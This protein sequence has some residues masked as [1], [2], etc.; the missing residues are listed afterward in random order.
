MHFSLRGALGVACPALLGSV[1]VVSAAALPAS[2]QSY[3]D[4]A[5]VGGPVTAAT[6]LGGGLEANNGTGVIKLSGSGVT[7]AL[8]GMVPSGV[9]LS[10]TTISYSGGVIQSPNPIVADATDKN[11]NAEALV[12]P[13]SLLN[14]DIQIQGFSSVRVAL[15]ALT[16]ANV[17]GTVRFSA[18]SSDN[19]DTVDFAESNLPAGLSSG[20][21]A[22]SY[23]GGTAAPG[24]YDGVVV[25]ATDADGAVLHGTFTLT[26]EADVVGGSSFG[27]EVNKFGNGFDVLRQQRHPGA[28]VAGWTATQGDPATRFILETGTHAGALRLEYAPQGSGTG[29]CVSD[30]GGG[31]STDPLPDGLVLARCNTGPWQQ[32]MPQSNGTLQNVATGLFVNPDGTGA[33]LRGGATATPWGGSSYHWKDHSGLPG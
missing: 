24:T 18:T 4:T 32:F 20:N 29:L 5:L 7:W 31:W 19:A 2:A 9:S 1:L 13:I 14:N 3:Q 25:I 11:G 6:Y 23:S 27:D 21:P 22:L 30:P 12:I 17:S 26:V 33:Q 8:H 28:I 15:S 16:D 10:G